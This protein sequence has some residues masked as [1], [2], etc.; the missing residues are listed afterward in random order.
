MINYGIPTFWEHWDSLS[1]DKKFNDSSFNSVGLASVGAYLFK[2]VAGIDTDDTAVGFQKFIIKPNVGLGINSTTIV[3]YPAYSLLTLTWKIFEDDFV[4]RVRN[5]FLL[6][7]TTN[8][9]TSFPNE[10]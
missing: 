1:V 9:T 2:Y 3:F 5:I 7:I 10:I 6:I 8:S 4:I